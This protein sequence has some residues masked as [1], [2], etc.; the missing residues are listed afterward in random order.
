MSLLDIP[1]QVSPSPRITKLLLPICLGLKGTLKCGIF[2][3]II[4]QHSESYKD[5]KGKITE[6]PEGA[7]ECPYLR[8]SAAV[9]NI[10][11]DQ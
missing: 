2:S 3:F 5:F 1:P 8:G 7:S 6:N 11:P 10:C 9:P 4:R